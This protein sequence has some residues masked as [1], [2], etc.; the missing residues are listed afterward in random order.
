MP[1]FSI[2]NQINPGDPLDATKAMANWNGII[3]DL[4]QSTGGV[5][6]DNLTATAAQQLGL[7]D[8]SHVRRGAIST[9]TA[10]STSSTVYTTLTTPDRVSN[11]VLPT[12]G[13]IIVGYQAIWQNTVANNGQ[14]AIFI[15]SSQLE[16]ANGTGSGGAP[17]AQAAS[18]N[19]T[20]NVDCPLGTTISGGLQSASAT[21][22]ATEVTTGELL[23]IGSSGN[24]GPAFIF[25]AAGTYDVSIQ[26]KNLAAGT[27][28]VK[29]RHL[30]V[31]TIGF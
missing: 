30:W 14:A 21:A 13:L 10:E 31:W 2:P 12:N 23:S 29:N 20:I 24:G 6:G 17:L 8:S 27:L 5:D 26:F 11:V 16:I 19:S 9:A 4:N 1:N 18:G 22:N 7:S 15:G 25:A 28:T 3:N